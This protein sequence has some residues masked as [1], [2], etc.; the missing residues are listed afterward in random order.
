[1]V[2][3]YVSRGSWG[4]FDLGWGRVL[5]WAEPLAWVGHSLVPC[6]NYNYIR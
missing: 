4:Y 5:I 1:M 6:F 3:V 2:S